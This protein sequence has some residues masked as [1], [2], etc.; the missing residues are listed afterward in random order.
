M[1]YS[2]I[3]RNMHMHML[4]NWQLWTS[5]TLFL[6]CHFPKTTLMAVGIQNLA[7]NTGIPRRKLR[8]HP[9]V[10]FIVEYNLKMDKIP[11]NLL[12]FGHTWYQTLHFVLNNG[13]TSFLHGLNLVCRNSPRFRHYS[14]R[15]DINK[16][17]YC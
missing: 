1:Y 14:I 10:Q 17:N 8:V 13:T 11:L 4:D 12:L 15:S 7:I 3:H 6:F 16:K 5:I 9:S 2:S